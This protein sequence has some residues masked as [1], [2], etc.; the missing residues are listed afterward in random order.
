MDRRQKKTRD[1]ILTV[2]SE[3][4]EH[5]SYEKITV[6]AIIDKA[7]VG[8][9]TFYA[10]FKT[11]DDLLRE[12]CEMLFEHIRVYMSEQDGNC[13]SLDSAD[14]VFCHLLRHLQRNDHNLLGLLSCENSDLFLRYFKDQ[15]SELVRRLLRGNHTRVDVPEDFLVNHITCSFVEMVRWWVQSKSGLTPEQLGRYF[16]S[17]IEPIL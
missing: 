11:K 12:L 6:Q 2:F 3:L 8:R 14:S 13:G 7:N 9:T 1:A 10:H 4:L 5:T 15:L 16:G 17:V